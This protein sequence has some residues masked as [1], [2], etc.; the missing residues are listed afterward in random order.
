MKDHSVYVALLEK[1]L[2]AKRLTHSINV[3][4]Q[5]QLLAKLYGADEEK[6]YFAGLLHDL[7]KEMDKDE[8]LQ[9]I[10]KSDI[11]LDSILQSQ[12]Q[13]WHGMAA[14]AYLQLELNVTD[15]AIIDSVRYHTTARAGMTTLEEIIYIADI[16]SKDRDYPDVDEMRRLALTDLSQAMLAGLQYN[17][18]RLVQKG[19]TISQDTFNAYNYYIMK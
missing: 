6:A 3:A 14:A 4:E 12:P 9:W 10:A 7:C 13:V 15:K 17:L 19:F 1:H 2:S 16:T 5:A 8:Q 11:I 18:T